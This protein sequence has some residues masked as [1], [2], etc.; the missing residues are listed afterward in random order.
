[1]AK[2][3]NRKTTA[4]T[5]VADAPAGG[6][7]ATRQARLRAQLV[8][9]GLDLCRR[10]GFDA[11]TV[12]DIAEA[13]GISRRTFF[14]YFDSKD[15]VVFDWVRE[16][17]ALLRPLLMARP[18]DESPMQA[19]VSVYLALSR[20]YDEDRARSIAVTRIVY[21]TPSLSRRYMDENARWED[22]MARI[23]ERGRSPRKGEAF[24]TRVLISSVTAAF[25]TAMKTWAAGNH[26]GPLLVWVERAFEALEDGLRQLQAPAPR[27]K[28]RR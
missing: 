25:V 17:G 8:H 19:I 3:K 20:H 5:S 28:A 9:H 26:T 4:R 2:P 24:A 1:M 27:R 7:R 11:T 13:A 21:E 10:H 23:V 14:R 12:S 18:A 6:S 15:D 22:D 16:Q